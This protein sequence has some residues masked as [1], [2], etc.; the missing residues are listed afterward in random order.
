MPVHFS[1]QEAFPVRQMWLKK[2]YEETVA[3]GFIPKSTFSAENTI[4]S[5][6]VGE[7]MVA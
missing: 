4:A 1:G 5:F 6:G 7:N 2:A 3:V